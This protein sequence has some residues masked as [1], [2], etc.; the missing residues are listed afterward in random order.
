MCKFWIRHRCLRFRFLCVSRIQV[1]RTYL[2]IWVPSLQEDKRRSYIID[3]SSSV[4]L[5]VMAILSCIECVSS[6]LHVS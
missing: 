3:R 4:V 1:K 5:Y 6:F 2:P